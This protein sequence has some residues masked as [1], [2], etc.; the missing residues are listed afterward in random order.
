MTFNMKIIYCLCKV[1]GER[2]TVMCTS[3][4]D[5]GSA[6]WNHS[7]AVVNALHFHLPHASDVSVA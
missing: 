7:P 2:V 5:S 3:L 4:H 1:A 6:S